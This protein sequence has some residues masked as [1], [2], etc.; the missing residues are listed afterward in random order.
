MA[1]F[2]LIY[3]IL[4]LVWVAWSAMLTYVFIKYRYPD[5]FCVPIVITFW[6]VCGIIILV[7]AGFIMSADWVTVPEVFKSIG[8]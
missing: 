4:V 2:L 5:S 3:I 6:V 7:S 8:I 1:I